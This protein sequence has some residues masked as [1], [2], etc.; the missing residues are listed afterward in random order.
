M[1]RFGEPIAVNP[2]EALDDADRVPVNVVV[3]EPVAVLKVLAF[4]DA[5]GSYE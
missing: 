4:R 5:V 2:T 3:D 1:Q